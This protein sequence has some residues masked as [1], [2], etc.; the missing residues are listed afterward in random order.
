MK[1]YGAVVCRLNFLQELPIYL[2]RL[3][4]SKLTKMIG[5]RPP[6]ILLLALQLLGVCR[7]QDC[8]NNCNNNGFCATD[9]CQCYP[10]FMGEDC[11]MVLP[12]SLCDEKNK[13]CMH[14]TTDAEHVYVQLVGNTTGWVAVIVAPVDGGMQKGELVD[15]LF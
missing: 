8:T 13:H 14:W 7:T 4:K 11:G 5:S 9:V 6:L 15:L 3:K 10:G 1:R 2:N 12:K